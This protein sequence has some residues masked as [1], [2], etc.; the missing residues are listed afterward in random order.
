MIRITNLR[1]AKVSLALA[2]VGAC[3]GS[4]TAAP[5]TV[6]VT[7]APTVVATTIS[8]PPVLA[9]LP[10][11]AVF[12]RSNGIGPFEF[13]APY[14]GDA[15]EAGIPLVRDS[16]YGRSYPVD[17]GGGYF[18]TTGPQLETFHYT[19]ARVICW[20]DGMD[21][22]NGYLC[23]YFG[24]PDEHNLMFV[25]WDYVS[26]TGPGGLFSSHGVTVN[27][28]ANELPA[29]PPVPEGSCGS[30][31]TVIVDG[32]YVGLVSDSGSVFGHYDADGTFARASPQP[33]D[34]R[35]SHMIA[36]ETILDT[37]DGGE[38]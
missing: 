34:A 1:L 14:D 22:H 36:G 18:C 10:T 13:G 21:A 25:G 24:G 3:S 8:V 20:D 32:I 37:T 26:A 12:L 5:E 35:V 11:T 27:V 16:D 31:T 23:A 4:E 33:F 15:F 7:S 2:L 29:L 19:R 6:A 38:C 28:L 17:C 9:T 30:R